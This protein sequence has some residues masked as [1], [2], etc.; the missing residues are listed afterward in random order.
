MR[1][2]DLDVSPAGNMADV[3][4]EFL[5]VQKD[6]ADELARL[7]VQAEYI[8]LDALRDKTFPGKVAKDRDRKAAD[9]LTTVAEYQAAFAE[10]SRAEYY[11]ALAT[12]DVTA[13]R[14]E[15]GLHKAW[16]YSQGGVR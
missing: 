3:Y 16:L 5:I 6:S 8:K 1:E 4:R 15:I 9:Y 14:E 10:V 11:L 12:V 7:K 2:Q 13:Y